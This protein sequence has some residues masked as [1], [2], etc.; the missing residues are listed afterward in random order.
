V[1]LRI[2]SQYVEALFNYHLAVVAFE[3]AKVAPVFS[4]FVIRKS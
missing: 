3:T 4:V 2:E 1:A